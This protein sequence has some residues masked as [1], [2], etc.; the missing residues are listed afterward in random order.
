MV[1]IIINSSVMLILFLS[2]SFYV[3]SQDDMSIVKGIADKILKE[4]EIGF[5]GKTTKTY[6][7]STESIPAD[8]DVF[9]KSKYA[10]WHYSMGVLDMAM[11]NLSRMTNNHAYSQFVLNHIDYCFANKPYFANRKTKFPG[12]PFNS[13]LRSDE[14]DDFGAMGA[15]IIDVNKISS[16]KEYTDFIQL[17]ASHI[18]KKQPRLTDGTLVRTWPYKFTL[19]ADDLYMGVSFLARMGKYSQNNIYYD[20]AIKQVLNFNKYLWNPT[21]ELYCHAYYADL[22][23]VG[24]AHWGRC[25]GWVMLATVHLLNSLP[26]NYPNQSKIIDLLKRHITGVSHYQDSEGLWH[27]LLDKSDSYSETS[28]S[29]IFVYSIARA[30]NQGWLDKRYASIALKGWDGLRKQKITSDFIIKDICIGTGIGTDLTYYYLRPKKDND[31]HGMGLI[32]DAGLEIINLKKT[33]NLK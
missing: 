17:A 11:L 24:G 5:I 10:D 25:N 7:P 23:C 8:E 6:Y 29:T 28:C 3:Q 20:D 31:I 12:G 4:N 19:W 22:D 27:Q 16:K 13:L 15:A 1:K 30:I 18:M 33:L 32:I 9:C 2:Q 26:E 21:K 14:L